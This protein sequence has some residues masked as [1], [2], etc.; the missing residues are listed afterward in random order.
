MTFAGLFAAAVAFVVASCSPGPTEV[1]IS[2]PAPTTE[3]TAPAVATDSKGR[4]P[5]GS[6]VYALESN[7][8]GL[9]PTE[10]GCDVPC[11]QILSAVADPLVT[12]DETGR[13]VP[14]LLDSIEPDDDFFTWRLT[15]RSGVTFHDGAE[16][17]GNILADHIDRCRF[18]PLTSAWFA[19]IRAIEANGLVVTLHL[20][21]P[22]LSFPQMLATHPC[23]FVVSGTSA[24]P[25]GTGPFAVDQPS[26]SGDG[27]RVSRFDA[28]WRGAQGT[29]EGL[30]LLDSVEFIVQPDLADRERLLAQGSIGVFHSSTSSADSP[31]TVRSTLGTDTYQLVFNTDDSLAAPSLAGAAPLGSIRACRTALAATTR[32]DQL[33]ASSGLVTTGPFG[34]DQLGYLAPEA[35]PTDL[36]PD[37]PLAECLRS[38]PDGAMLSI[39]T[40]ADPSAERLATAISKQ[41]ELATDGQISVTVELTDA[42]ALGQRALSGDFD[43]VV[44]R[45]GGGVHPDASFPW[46]HSS[47]VM[48]IGEPSLNVGRFADPIIDASLKKLRVDELPLAQQLAA[49]EITRAFRRESYVLWLEWTQWSITAAQPVQDLAVAESP[50]GLDLSP[51]VAGA[52]AV[53]QIWCQDAICQGEE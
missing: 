2:I 29:G 32:L 4:T 19:P 43:A 46:W 18:S 35:L 26:V 27:L 45:N 3:T 42:A 51:V 14:F 11:R 44:W 1:S 24:H 7:A 8:D 13:T 49:E 38:N 5:G 53:S 48:S 30:P 34:P 10:S 23:A 50:E 37:Q 41:W 9:L 52:H 47:S 12:V 15:L 28:Y 21:E 17:D 33:G 39:L 6:L 31:A 20:E 36:D 40:T 16:L 22:W 25:V